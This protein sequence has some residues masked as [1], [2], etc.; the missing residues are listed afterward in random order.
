MAGPL[1]A[2]ISGLGPATAV[3]LL[4]RNGGDLSVFDCNDAGQAPDSAADG[5]WTCGPG[6]LDT[7]VATVGLLVDGKLV[8]A[9][10]AQW[11]GRARS[12]SVDR[13]E[14]VTQL[15]TT[16]R[17]GAPGPNVPPAGPGQTLIVEV[18]GFVGEGAPVVHVATPTGKRQLNCG[19]D[20]TFP[21]SK[22]NDGLLGC[23]GVLPG[24]VAS[25]ELFPAGGDPVAFGEVAF[26]GEPVVEVEV[27]V[28]AV[29]MKV[30]ATGLLRAAL[31]PVGSPGPSN[32]DGSGGDGP[33][34]NA[35]DG[36]PAGDPSAPPEPISPKER[37]GGAAA[38]ETASLSMV[39]PPHPLADPGVA[40]LGVVA[41]AIGAG[42]VA[43]RRRRPGG[44]L[45]ALRRVP[46]RPLFEGGPSISDGGCQLRTPDP[47]A[48]AVA[49]APKLA[50]T[51]RLLVA[52]A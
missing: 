16:A 21:D 36:S 8:D 51:R 5:V 41:V 35:G 40:A 43:G 23:A 14:G 38:G 49:L 22:R 13:S 24:P 7:D 48:L 44:A 32:D 31:M 28:A 27:D 17:L 26:G 42:V 50:A 6:E 2:R 37:A 25:L 15:S 33:G 11:S 52:S 12:L 39:A 10:E 46:S 30:G 1:D 4:A 29:T 18:H 19:D 34:G 9:G 47:D 20:G 45:D 3:H